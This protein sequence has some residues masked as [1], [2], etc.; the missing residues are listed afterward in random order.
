MSKNPFLNDVKNRFLPIPRSAAAGLEHEPQKSDFEVIKELGDG[1]FATVYLVSHKKTKAKYAFKCIDKRQPQNL[2][3]KENF[4]REV[5]IMYKL[6]HPNIVKLFGHFEDE[7]YCYFLMQYIPNMNLF[8]LMEFNGDKHDLKLIVSI[9]KDL[10]NAIYYLHNMK[11][12]IIHRDIKPEN[13]LLDE[14]Y[15]AYLTDFG[16]SNYLEHYVKRKTFCGTPMYLSPEM[17]KENGHDETVDIWCI[18]V[19]LFE[20]I[21][22]KNP[23]DDQDMDVVAYNISTININWPDN[24]DPDAKDLISKILKLKGKDRLSIENILSHKFFNR[25][26]PNAVDELIKPEGIEEKIFVVSTD[27]PT[28]WGRQSKQETKN[29]FDFRKIDNEPKNKFALFKTEAKNEHVEGEVPENYVR[30]KNRNLTAKKMIDDKH[31][32]T[33]KK[34]IIDSIQRA[35]INLTSNKDSN[36]NLIKTSKKDLKETKKDNNER[37]MN[38]IKDSKLKTK[39]SNEIRINTGKDLKD[40]TQKDLLSKSYMKTDTNQTNQNIQTKIK[41]TRRNSNIYPNET[42]IPNK[43]GVTNQTN[44]NTANNTGATKQSQNQTRIISLRNN[45]SI[46]INKNVREINK[47]NIHNS[48]NTIF[49]N[50]KRSATNNYDVDIKRSF[51]NHSTYVSGK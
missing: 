15:K 13:I 38:T 24:I 19:L 43:L 49:K 2:S 41:A 16:W 21:T 1:T 22:G 45:K 9:M 37:S 42:N 6:N 31:K 23:F 47:I 7:N 18:G 29:I 40:T 35:E 8:E 51:N 30:N 14:N 34:I 10:I 5:E 11:P 33:F 28:T 3:E 46:H 20:L 44:K 17:F 25:Y 50:F 39:N 32:K 26:F 27:D 12:V 4:N 48:H 36:N